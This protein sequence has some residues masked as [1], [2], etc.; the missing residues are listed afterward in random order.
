MEIF[1]Q[2]LEVLKNSIRKME[3]EIVS[4][5]GKMQYKSLQKNIDLY[6][7]NVRAILL[8]V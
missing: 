1:H 2:Y 6:E 7:M 3:H 5:I 8:R 4:D